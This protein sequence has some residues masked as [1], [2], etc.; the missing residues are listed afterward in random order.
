[1]NVFLFGSKN[2]SVY[3]LKEL[4]K[5]NFKIKGVLTRDNEPNMKVWHEK[6]NHM[7]LKQEASSL[8]I[9]VYEDVS[10]NSNE[11]E[12]I[13]TEQ[14]IDFAIGVFWGEIIKERILNL[15]KFGFYNLHTAY[16]PRDRGSF[17]MAWPIINGEEFAGITFHKMANGVDNGPI[18]RQ[19]K[20]FIDV[21]ETG[22]S[23]YD[24]VTNSGLELFQEVLPSIKE[25]KFKL[26][27]QN[28]N[29]ASYHPRGYP[30]GGYVDPLWDS[31]KKE[32]FKR[33]LHFP[34]FDGHKNE[35]KPFIKHH[36]TPSVRVMIGFDCDR[37][38]GSFIASKE[39]QVMAKRKITSLEN[40]SET[41][42]KEK[43][44]RTFFI[45]GNFIE[46]MVHH[47]GIS[48]LK[49]AFKA[50]GSLVEIADHSFSH[51]TVK[52]IKTRPD[53]VPATF[54]EIREEFE[55]NTILFSKYFDGMNIENR[56]YRTPLGH[57]YGLRG[58]FK[59]LNVFKDLN[60]NYISSDLRDANESLHP[61]L[62]SEDGNIR[63]PYRYENGL[64]EIPSIGW[65]D[66]AFSQ[67]SSTDLYEIPPTTY[68]DII[69][70]YQNLFLEAKQLSEK[71]N[72]D[73]F[74]GLV[75]H[76]YDVSF[77][78][79]NNSLFVDLKKKLYSIN[80]SFHT[81]LEVSTPTT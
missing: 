76:P 77:Y 14:N 35:P 24:K 26:H 59:L 57:K 25:W 45:C 73:I 31:G 3:V 48:R 2:L 10:I 41:L 64:L 55:T 60:I 63:Q 40:I 8:G 67:N 4:Y 39:G 42:E 30:Y 56:G 46:S 27:P 19:K 23:L 20:V 38:R 47:F 72:R 21:N 70:Y 7:S 28:E 43:I 61:K 29:N 78:D 5:N 68:S 52:S 33:A 6:L 49:N 53:K 80:G 54:S 15:S 37:P 75:M 74:L 44:P 9:P 1:M 79:L 13:F 16:L 62:I 17:P 50:Y 69:E 58:E 12:N 71:L 51:K 22:K 65:Q 18:I 66:T 81:Y 32:R 11:F 34:P 36:K